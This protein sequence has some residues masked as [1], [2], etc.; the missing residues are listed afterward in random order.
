[1][2]TFTVNDQVFYDNVNG[3]ALSYGTAYFGLPYKNP[4][5]YP[6]QPFSDDA[7]TAPISADQTLTDDG[8][9]SGTIYLNGSYSLVVEDSF[10]VVHISIPNFIDGDNVPGLDVPVIDNSEILSFGTVLFGEKAQDPNTNPKNPYYDEL[11]TI[12][13]PASIKLTS[14]GKV[15]N[16]LHFDGDYSKYY[17]DNNG[18]LRV[19]LTGEN[20]GY[21]INFSGKTS[22]PSVDDTGNYS[23]TTQNYTGANP[24]VTL[25]VLNN[26]LTH[27]EP[28]PHKGSLSVASLLADYNDSVD[29][30]GDNNVTL[31]VSAKFDTIDNYQDGFV[32][33]DTVAD[34]QV[35]RIGIVVNSHSYEDPPGT[36]NEAHRFRMNLAFQNGASYNGSYDDSPNI[37]KG[38]QCTIKL[39]KTAKTYRLYVNDTLAEEY[40]TTESNTA[41]EWR[42]F[43]GIAGATETNVYW[44]KVIL[45]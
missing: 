6:K 17:Y 4:K 29:A 28:I 14:A 27:A 13:A 5:D 19:A 23:L 41:M 3:L 18:Q 33:I 21:Y 7:Y 44:Y 20:L 45:D 30:S 16:A 42:P 40:T 8:K 43:I 35:G 2:T 11:L 26:S 25:A 1:M 9:I 22:V 32:A 10:G 37:P 38:T 39:V 34:P 31:E 36:N 15:P 24:G 12:P